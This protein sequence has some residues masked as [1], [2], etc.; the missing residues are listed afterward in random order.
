MRAAAPVEAGKA[1]E[2]KRKAGGR[3]AG[4]TADLFFR[5]AGRFHDRIE[6]ALSEV[7]LS[8]PTFLAL[9]HLVQA[10]KPLPLGQLAAR[11]ECGKSHMTQVVDRLEADR[12]VTRV[13][14]PDDRRSVLAELTDEGRRRHRE[15]VGAVGRVE[16]E[17][18]GPLGER[19]WSELLETLGRL[20]E[21]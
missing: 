7:G 10:G 1:G 20:V 14:D 15:G 13:P 17:F 3:K 6:R 11:T 16:E 8:V 5:V 21:E 2:G 19:R 4:Q 18:L 9:K 12:L